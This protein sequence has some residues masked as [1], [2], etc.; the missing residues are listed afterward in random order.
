MSLSR[1]LSGCLIAAVVCSL[2]VRAQNGG[3]TTFFEGARLIVGDASAPIENS[4]FIVQGDSI[5]WVGRRGERQPPAGAARVDLTGKTVMPA[6]I[7]GHNHIGLVNERDGTNKKEN[8]TRENLVD[9]LER[10]AYY[11]TAAALSMGLEANPDV[12]YKLRDEVIPNAARYYTVGK[13]IAATPMAGPVGE[14]RLG[15]PYGAASIEEGLKDVRELKGHGT[16]FVKIWVDDREGAVPK[17]KPDVYRAI[18]NEAHKG[19][20]QVLAHLSRTS[21]LEDAKDLFKAGVDGFVHE[22]RD[23]DVDDEYLALVKSHPKVWTGPNM[24]GPGQTMEDVNLLAETLPAN[25]IDRM[26]RGVETRMAAGNKPNELYELHCRNLRKIHDAGMIIGLGTDGTGDGFG[27]LEQILYYTKCGMTAK[28][29]LMAGT[30]VNARILFMDKLGTVAAGKE[31]SFIVLN[32]NPLDDITN[33]RKIA[34]VYL[35]GKEV[36]RKG[37]RTKWTGST[38]ATK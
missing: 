16:K 34:N 30:S 11:G 31:A 17:I 28:E 18:I 27:P 7:D 20:Q 14:A 25:Q 13:G 5:T 24:P 8:Y 3:A 33:T 22:V 1:I 4:A 26:R 29:A 6:L 32:A 9:Q 15:I 35:R 19:G 23:R 36:D 10:Y 12:S 2:E 37:L 38:P 21:A